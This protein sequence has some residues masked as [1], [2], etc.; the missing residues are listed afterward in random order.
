MADLEKKI[1]RAIADTDSFYENAPCGYLS[2]GADGKVIKINETLLS[3][4]NYDRDEVVG[5][6]KF[7]DL[8]PKGGQIYYE[9]FYYPLLQL[10]DVV[11][12]ISFDLLR[13]D[14]SK[15]PALVNS[16][17]KLSEGAELLIIDVTVF[18]ITDRKK[19]E[20]ELLASKRAADEERKRF[21]FLSDFVPEMIWTADPS[22]EINY[23]NKRFLNFFALE[24]HAAI[25]NLLIN[26]I[27]PEDR[28]KFLRS[29]LRALES[30]NDF[31]FQVRLENGSHFKWFLIRAVAFRGESQEILKWMGACTNIDEQINALERRDEFIKVASHE[32]RTP[33]TSMTVALQL[34]DR[35]KNNPAKMGTLSD[36]IVQSNSAIKK[37][38]RLVD[39]LLNTERIKDG[40]IELSRNK[41]SVRSLLVHCCD[42][43]DTER[44]D[45]NIDCEPGLMVL[46]DENRIEQVV[47]NF[48]NNAIKYAPHSKRLQVGGLAHG[49]G[50]KI[51]VRDFGPGIAEENIPKLFDRYF[52]AQQK[53]DKYAGL[54]LGL[55]ICSEIIKKHGGSIGVE[56]TVGKGSEFYFNLPI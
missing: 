45:V 22:G 51:W 39:D 20:R 55:Y 33:I 30:G 2:F 23:V 54:G 7:K 10:Q 50:I 49:E 3:W 6:L 38:T 37:L 16:L 24:N 29:W 11:K 13:K 1:K 40:Q 14:G 18:D 9:M 26:K 44:M 15:I 25:G 12:E 5:K 41:F 35:Y 4:L 56:S 52:Q 21:E 27:H 34:M 47:V 17:V 19:Y 46:A 42:L 28:F 8:L 53:S 32:L 43:V 48:L 31:E 36:L